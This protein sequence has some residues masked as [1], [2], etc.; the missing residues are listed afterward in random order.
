MKFLEV[1]PE[2]KGKKGGGGA[3]KRGGTK[4]DATA[5]DDAGEAE[6]STTQELEAQMEALGPCRD[7]ADAMRRLLDAFIFPHVPPEAKVDSGEFGACR[8]YFSQ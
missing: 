5:T 3:K 4:K 6:D 8:L 1:R 7:V 2:K